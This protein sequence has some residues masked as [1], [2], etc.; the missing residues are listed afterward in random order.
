VPW[1]FLFAYTASGLAGLIYEVGWTRLITLHIGHSIGAA[2]TVVAA[3]LGG[4]AVGAA[5]GGAIA[6]RM[7]PRR[8]L[9]AY[10]MVEIGVAL[11]ALALPYELRAIEP[12]LAWS[13]NDGSPGPWFPFIRVVSCLLLVSVPA[14]ALGASFPFAIRW[15]T[16][17]SDDAAAPGGMLYFLNTAGAAA[18]AIVAGFLLIPSVGISGT[19]LVGVAASLLAAGSVIAILQLRI[20]PPTGRGRERK[21]ARGKG[22][23]A[24]P[25]AVHP[26]AAA[27]PQLWLAAAVLA[28]SGF[29][30]LTHEIAWTR[31]LA[32]VFGPTVYA[33]AATLAAVIAGLAIGSGIGTWMVRRTARAGAGLALALTAAA[34][35]TSA[36]YSM[37][38]QA[39]PRLAAQQSAAASDTYMPVLAYGAVLTAVLI[40][41]T[42]ACLGA[43][44]PLALSLA[45]DRTDQAARRF[46]FVYA[47]NTIG[48]VSGSLA[49]GFFFIPALG[50][51]NTLRLVSACLIAASVLVLVRGNV[52]RKNRVTGAFASVI[53]AAALVF[54]PAWDRE[55]LASGAYLYAP[56]VPR[57]LDLEM[58]LKAG[59][60]LY[61]EEGSSATVSVKK[62]TGTTTL[63]V[64]GKTDASNRGDMLTQKLVAHLPLLLHDNPR[65]VAIVGLGSGV[66]VGAAL[67]HPI[68]RADVIEISPEVVEASRFFVEENHRALDDP[69][70]NLILG[71]GRSHLLLSSR[72]YD[73]IISEPSNPWIAGVAS[74]FTREFFEAARAR[75]APG[76]VMCQWANAYNIS[77]ADLR[78]IVAT[79]QSVFP[80][81]TAWLVGADDVLLIATDEP[82]DGRLAGIETHWTRPGVAEDLAEVAAVEPFVLWSLF[83]GGPGELARY[84][85][86]AELLTDDTMRLEFSGPGELHGR[87]SG[88]N[89][90]ILAALLQPD[91]GPAVIRQARASAGAAQWR[92]RGVMLAKRDAYPLAYDDFIKAL[93]MD[94]A[95]DAALDGLVRSAILIDHERE[96]LA[97]LEALGGG[98]GESS[99]MLV[100]MSKLHAAAG[101]MPQ[102]I[103]AARRARAAAPGTVRPLEQLGTL[104]ADSGDLAALDAT[105]ADLQR[106]APDA[107]ATHY[108]AAVAALLRDRL[109]D[110]VR[111]ARLAIE[112]DPDYLPTYDLIGAAYTRLDRPDE[113]RAAF[114]TSLRLDPHD[115]TAY[116]NIGLLELAAGNRE[117][118]AR[119]FA[120]G[121][122]LDPSSETA[123]QG[124]ART[125]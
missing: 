116:I 118:A 80:H 30:S 2:S 121:L 1:L 90:E 88:E 21:E 59:T 7:S 53:A 87:R 16:S 72:R 13:Y 81:G 122:W 44:F 43:A 20:A 68:T 18:G 97:A 17:E 47:V 14:V 63:A 83:V 112:R 79:F 93:S 58:L 124:L 28:L 24:S 33:F 3:F 103:E 69:R 26:I 22:R 5:A 55:L 32:L 8:S 77:D 49:A 106:V 41:P 36:T 9:Q 105:V 110:A 92:N 109:E 78:S 89:G 48:S 4:L 107:A 6:A 46:G 82:L 23:K 114:E 65:E 39:I 11:A 86:G 40:I 119:Y 94:P 25:R 57:D 31:I 38:G 19:T 101:E 67:R 99:A 51:Q 29:A 37:A 74:L 76:G 35:I 62:L 123:R 108:L 15:F 34:I 104:Y 71:D 42:A 61:Y 113:A 73:V 27:P 125:R 50:L 115:S 91:G 52:S 54:S 84:S 85:A 10:A 56:F 102:A 96:A 100:A 45:N 111:L 95:D 120:E 75:L 60:L 98:D 117:A 12:I 70:T 64:D 66:T